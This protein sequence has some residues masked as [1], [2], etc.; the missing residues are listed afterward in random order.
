M[1]DVQRTYASQVIENQ[2]RSN[3][4]NSDLAAAIVQL[5]H[6]GIPVEQIGT[7]C[8]L[9]GYQ[10]TA[11]RAVAKFPPF[12]VE[13]LD[14]A[15]VRALYDLYRQ[16]TKTPEE[17]ESAMP[18][19]GAFVSITEA[20]RIV[21]AITGKATGSIVL[22]TPREDAQ[23]GKGRGHDPAS[24]PSKAPPEILHGAGF[25]ESA[26]GQGPSTKAGKGTKPPSASPREMSGDQSPAPSKVND[27]RSPKPDEMPIFIVAVG[28]GEQGQLVTDRRAEASGWALV[29]YATGIE[30]IELSSLRIVAV[31]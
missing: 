17:V 24:E 13:R 11:Y 10:V 7:L 25:S 30:E 20:R 22:E 6:E 27:I 18:D 19:A 29:R 12:L 2:Q 16:W 4:S 28:E 1:P 9:K 15:D 3:L 14:V 26:A 21:A 23:G 8:N 5:H 31:E